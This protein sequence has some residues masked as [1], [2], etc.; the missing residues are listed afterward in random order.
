[1]EL[2]KATIELII[3]IVA[4]NTPIFFV[5]FND[6]DKIYIDKVDEFLATKDTSLLFPLY[7]GLTSEKIKEYKLLCKNFYLNI[8][9]KNK[10][11]DI[12]S[13]KTWIYSKGYNKCVQFFKTG[14][15][16]ISLKSG[17]ENI[18]ISKM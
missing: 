15:K 13:S 16:W 4:K 9:D 18:I 8:M 17:I 2:T 7:L 11:Q 14:M 5:S 1:N 3:P 12:L 6:L 10:I